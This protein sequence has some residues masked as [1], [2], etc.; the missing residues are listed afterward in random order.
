MT[1]QWAGGDNRTAREDD[2]RCGSG[3]IEKLESIEQLQ[4]AARD[5]D[6]ERYGQL[7]ADDATFRAA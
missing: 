1:Q 2:V 3:G 7:L 5:Q 6:F 4:E